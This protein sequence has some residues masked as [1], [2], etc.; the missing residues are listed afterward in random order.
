M[1]K[2]IISLSMIA[3]VAAIAVGATTAFFSDTETSTGNTFTAGAIDLGVDNTSYL[4][5]ALNPG[6][7]W[8][9][10][11][12][13]DNTEFPGDNL[14]TP[15]VENGY[16]LPIVR[17]FFNF[18]DLKPGDLGEDTISLHVNNNDSYLCADVTLTST[19]DNSSTEPEMD[20]GDTLWTIDNTGELQN[21]VKFVWWAD[22]G[23]NVLETDE[24]PI[25][26]NVPLGTGT[27]ALADS[28]QNIWGD[29]GPL[30]GGSDRFI[31]KAW[32]FGQLTLEPVDEGVSPIVDGGVRCNGENVNNLSQ[33]D[34]MSADIAFRAVQSRNNPNFVCND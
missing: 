16:S 13:I 28:D 20:D 6:T 18:I 7:T 19:L 32:C 10:D 1:K 23:D 5:G 21:Y 9:L 26:E 15:E 2:I 8:G 30:P 3:A 31:G 33:T 22:D 24:N 27:V 17:Q 14:E 25:H 12:D 34:S 29:N 11:F 4:N